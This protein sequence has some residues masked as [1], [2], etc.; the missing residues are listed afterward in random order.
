M[1]SKYGNVAHVVDGIRFSSKAEAKRWVELAWLEKFAQVSNVQR[2]VKWELLKKDFNGKNFVVESYVADFVYRDAA[3]NQVVED[4]KGF[5]TRDFI[6]KKKWMWL[7]Y[8]VQIVEVGTP[9][10]PKKKPKKL[11]RVFGRR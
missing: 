5:R 4:V 7:V 10:K 9:R 1:T 11:D 8:G 3:G 6:R 2:Q